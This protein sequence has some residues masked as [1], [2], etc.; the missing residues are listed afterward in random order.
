MFF[1][2]T[3]LTNWPYFY[4]RI[5]LIII[6]RLV[7]AGP[8][9]FPFGIN[10]LALAHDALQGTC[11]LLVTEPAVISVPVPGDYYYFFVFVYLTFTIS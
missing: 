10:G 2:E 6:L 8:C 7:V 3:N 5:F 1:L 11:H 4:P 9:P